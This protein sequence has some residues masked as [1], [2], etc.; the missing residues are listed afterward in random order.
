MKLKL[1]TID[2]RAFWE[3]VKK[4]SNTSGLAAED[5]YRFG[6]LAQHLNKQMEGMRKDGLAILKKY[7]RKDEKGEILNWPQGPFLFES[8]EIEETHDKELTALLDKEFEVA[9]TPVK[10]SKIRG[11]LGLTPLEITALEPILELDVSA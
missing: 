1:S 7:A 2:D 10:L 8:K 11:N 5:A 6:R 9:V 4:M 3:A